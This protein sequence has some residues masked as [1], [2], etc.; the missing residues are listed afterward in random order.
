MKN[1]SKSKRY[2]HDYR[3]TNHA[4]GLLKYDFHINDLLTKLPD[5]EIYDSYQEIPIKE[6]SS[7]KNKLIPNTNGGK[8]LS[9]YKILFAVK[10]KD[11]G[12]IK[13]CLVYQEKACLITSIVYKDYQFRKINSL[14]NGWFICQCC[15]MAE[16]QF[17][18]LLNNKINFYRYILDLC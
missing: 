12:C 2:E 7:L 8:K 9:K 11:G 6:Y 4:P 3:I 14:E 13:A 15:M 17:W 5:T 16:L 10:N 1:L 18:K